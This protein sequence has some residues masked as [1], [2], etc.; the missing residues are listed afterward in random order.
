MS[1]KHG[2]EPVDDDRRAMEILYYTS[3]TIPGHGR[4]QPCARRTRGWP[5]RAEHSS[6]SPCSA[7]RRAT[8]SQTPKASIVGRHRSRTSLQRWSSGD[9]RIT[10]R[11]PGRRRRATNLDCGDSPSRTST[12]PQ[13]T[14]N[15]NREAAGWRGNRLKPSKPNATSWPNGSHDAARATQNGSPTRSPRPRWATTGLVALL[16]DDGNVDP[17]KVTAAVGRR[18]RP[19]GSTPRGPVRPRRGV[20]ADRSRGPPLHQRLPPAVCRPSQ[21]LP[22]AAISGAPRVAAGADPMAFN[23]T[24]RRNHRRG[25]DR[26]RP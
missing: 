4:P 17:D 19:S 6:P 18:S 9:D 7:T 11:R 8:A 26:D 20:F 25:Q 2:P 14:E 23:L 15:E 13:I 10:G 1:L 5:H 3:P 12:R 16:D 22:E 24:G 21:I